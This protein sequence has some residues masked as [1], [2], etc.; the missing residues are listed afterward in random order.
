MSSALARQHKSVSCPC[1]HQPLSPPVSFTQKVGFTGEQ[2]TRFSTETE[3]VA[4][5]GRPAVALLMMLIQ[6]NSTRA[7]SQVEEIS[8]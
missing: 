3:R 1:P 6:T 4:K 8:L 5:Y 2:K 7:P